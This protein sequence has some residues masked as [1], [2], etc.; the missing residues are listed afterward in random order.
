MKQ[1]DLINFN[2]VLNSPFWKYCRTSVIF[3]FLISSIG[4]SV[5]C[6]LDFSWDQILLSD[7]IQFQILAKQSIGFDPNP[8]TKLYK[9][10]YKNEYNILNIIN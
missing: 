10:V 4:L 8:S 3:I 2:L 9:T 1:S 7:R 6:K 5:N